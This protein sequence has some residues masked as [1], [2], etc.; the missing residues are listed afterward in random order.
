MNLAILVLRVCLGIMFVGHGLQK[1]FGM[2]GG[3]G[4]NGFSQMLSG[5]GFAPPAFWAYVVAYTEL[6]GGLLLM[7]GLGVRVSSLMLLAIMIVATWKVHLKAG[8]FLQAGGFEYNFIIIAVCLALIITGAGKFA[9][10][11]GSDYLKSL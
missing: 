1:A 5:L 3:P 2:F 8:F 6:I 9:L 4:I 11:A 7:L 10:G